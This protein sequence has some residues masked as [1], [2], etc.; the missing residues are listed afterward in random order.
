M[1]NRFYR[2]VSAMLLLCT[3]VCVFYLRER[4]QPVS[5][6]IPV[7]RVVSYAA[8]ST[9]EPTPEQSYRLQR[10]LQ[11]SKEMDALS[12]LAQAG[13]EQAAAYLKRMIDWAEKE[14]AIEQALAELGY[15]AAVCA[16]RENAV[17]VCLNEQ[18]KS[19]KAQQIIEVCMRLSGECAENVFLLDENGYS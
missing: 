2:G 6:Q 5:V 19:E 1:K 12:V 17:M 4:S 14:L 16:V 15:D 3:A 8:V 7:T 18:L 11:R 10:E 9:K 13:D